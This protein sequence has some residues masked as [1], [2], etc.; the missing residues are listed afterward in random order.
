MIGRALEVAE[1]EAL[2]DG[3]AR[4]ISG[5]LLVSGE[6]GIGKTALLQH[7]RDH[8]RGLRVLQAT[9]SEGETRLAFAGLADLLAPILDHIDELPATQAQTLSGALALGPPTPGD[10]FAAYVATLRLLA[11]AAEERPV[12]CLVDDAH[13]LDSESLEAL[14]FSARR[15]VAEGIAIV[16]AGREGISAPLDESTVPRRRLRGLA[17]AEASRL[18]V[19]R[20]G[21]APNARV[22]SALAAGTGGNPLA[23]IELSGSL[24]ADQLAGREALPDPLP[25]GRHLGTALLRPLAALPPATRRALLLASSDDGS[26]ELLTRALAGEGLAMTDLEPAERAGV[27]FVG[28]TRVAFSHPLV[29]AAVYQGADAPDRRA[30]HRAHAAA[31]QALGDAGALDRRAWH[32]A[33][34]STGPDESVAAALEDAAERAGARTAYAAACEALETAARLSPETTE[35]GRRLI[36]AGMSAVAGGAFTRAARL[37]DEVVALGAEP[38]Q[39]MEGLA[40]RG[41]VE[42]FGG[43]TRRAVDML[44]AA[45]ERVEA[46]SPVVATMLCLQ[47]VIP[48]FMRADLRRAVELTARAQE[49]VSDPP[50]ALAAQLDAASSITSTYVG[51]PR[52]MRPSS[53]AELRRQVAAGEPLGFIWTLGHL[54]CLMLQERYDDALEGLD[55]TIAAARENG[56]PSALPWPLA[57]RAE[58]RRRTG[59]LGE[60]AADAAEALDLARDTGQQG[61]AGYALAVLAFVDAVLGRGDDCRAHARLASRIASETDALSL[62]TLAETALGLLEFGAGDLGEAERRLGAIARDFTRLE[63]EHPLIDGFL[64]DLAEVRARLESAD[65]SE[66][67][68][69]LAGQA[70]ATGAVWAA[71]AAARARGLLADDDGFEGHF[72]E[73]LALHDRTTTPFE[74]GRTLLCLGER[75]RRARRVREARAPLASALEVFEVLGA[76]PWADWARRELRASGSRARR[77]TPAVTGVLTPQ[78]LQVALTVARGATNR[79]TATALMISPK[80]VE[81]HLARVYAKLGVRSRAELAGRMA[82]GTS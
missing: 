68:A 77:S 48:C 76:D 29:R 18:L 21:A 10:R 11:A 55:A 78:E 20:L 8:A 24:S 59:R 42:M 27:V 61:L 80:T 2:V 40:G 38:G 12:L 73:A 82:R 30:A 7:A 31:A 33:L 54:Q 41:Y 45:A 70:E 5:A 47:A 74:R 25:V 17:E 75:R 62:H 3:A 44:A 19:G 57:A 16:M 46:T 32:L 14:L 81:Y 60:A 63:G 36:A 35:R 13:W 79:E 56:T 52:S 6:P 67:V 1:V 64:C 53:V 39:V 43:S 37:F 51:R 15:L 26:S 9:G 72:A 22:L 34:S 28:P 69:V 66:T 49:L 58:V 71:A 65:A 4:G 50:P 23:L